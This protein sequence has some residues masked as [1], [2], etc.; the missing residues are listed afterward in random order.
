MKELR[1]IG[2]EKAIAEKLTFPVHVITVSVNGY[3][4]VVRFDG[5]SQTVAGAGFERVV[6]YGPPEETES[7]PPI[8]LVITDSRGHCA[9]ITFEPNLAPKWMM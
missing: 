2:L 5:I 3:V 7:R 8:V 9:H 6:G 1:D 4:D